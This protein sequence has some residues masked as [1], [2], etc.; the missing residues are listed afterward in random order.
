[1]TVAATIVG[2]WTV[3]GNGLMVADEGLIDY[4]GRFKA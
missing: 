1:M 4:A 2:G 3:V